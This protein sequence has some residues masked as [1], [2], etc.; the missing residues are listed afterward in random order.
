MLAMKYN[1]GIVT[2]PSPG[3]FPTN[4]GEI[5]GLIIFNPPFTI[6]NSNM[7]VKRGLIITFSYCILLMALALSSNPYNAAMNILT[8]LCNMNPTT[9]IYTT[10]AKEFKKG[11]PKSPTS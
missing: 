9:I 8:I 4:R 1:K 11:S 6:N 7:N 3:G 5:I 2:L 10:H